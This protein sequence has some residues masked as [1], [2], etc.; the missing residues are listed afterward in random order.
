[1]QMYNS[2]H[3]HNNRILTKEVRKRK[4]GKGEIQYMWEGVE[5]EREREGGREGGRE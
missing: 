1:M 3:V 4:G 5:W 2:T